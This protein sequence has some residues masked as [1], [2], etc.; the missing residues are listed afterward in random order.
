MSAILEIVV[1]YHYCWFQQTAHTEKDCAPFLA[2]QQ[3]TILS[4]PFSTPH[5]LI[6]TSTML[7]LSVRGWEF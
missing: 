4:F 3:Q 5:P 2:Q 1:C 6:L 7:P